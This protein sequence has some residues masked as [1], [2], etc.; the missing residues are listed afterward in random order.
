MKG[1]THL[2]K[3]IEKPKFA[4]WPHLA[5]MGLCFRDMF[6]EDCVSSKDDSV[7]CITVDGK[8][9]NISLDTRVCKAKPFCVCRVQ[10]SPVWHTLLPTLSSTH[11]LRKCSWYQNRKPS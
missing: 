5:L 6:G 9:A 10:Q 3:L 1:D 8:T 11:L 2:T 7:L 4:V